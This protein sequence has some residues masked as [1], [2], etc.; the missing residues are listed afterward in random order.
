MID[1][2]YFVRIIFRAV[3]SAFFKPR[4]FSCTATG[5][6]PFAAPLARCRIFA[7]SDVFFDTVPHISYFGSAPTNLGA[8]SGR[9]PFA[10]LR[11]PLGSEQCVGFL[12]FLYLQVTLPFCIARAISVNMR[13]VLDRLCPCGS[14][15]TTLFGS[16]LEISG[17]PLRRFELLMEFRMETSALCGTEPEPIHTT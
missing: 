8:R 15:R 16:A 9:C 3:Q 1:F 4:H 2:P 17:I 14:A 11:W 5:L 13:R 12:I 7:P 6:R 10:E